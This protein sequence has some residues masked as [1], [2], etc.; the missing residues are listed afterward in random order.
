[1]CQASVPN[2]G[3]SSQWVELQDDVRSSCS[4]FQM[5]AARLPHWLCNHGPDIASVS[6]RSA[7]SC[8]EQ[9]RSLQQSVTIQGPCLRHAL[10]VQL[11]G[12]EVRRAGTAWADCPRDAKCNPD[13]WQARRNAHYV[14]LLGSVCARAGRSWHELALE[15]ATTTNI[16]L[17]VYMFAPDLR[18]D[19]PRTRH[20]TMSRVDSRSTR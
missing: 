19:V 5:R 2:R 10:P 11:R 18:P 3:A 14:D 17:Q 9:W 16:S 7:P 8:L 20:L 15:V 4:I 12:L 6:S 1:V 13:Q